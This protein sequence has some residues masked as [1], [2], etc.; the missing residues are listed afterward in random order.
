MIP[1]KTL[2]NFV[3]EG[4][5]GERHSI[6]KPFQW[7]NNIVATNGHLIVIVPKSLLSGMNGTYIN[8]KAPSVDDVVKSYDF[9]TDNKNISYKKL[10]A[11]FKT[12]KWVT[13]EYDTEECELCRSELELEVRKKIILTPFKWGDYK[14]NAE[15]LLKITD[16]LRLYPEDWFYYV[17]ENEKSKA[18]RFVFVNKNEIKIIIMGMRFDDE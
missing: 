15:C 1:I 14:I 10:V 3:R 6:N 9:K 17:E 2:E 7:K 16:I 18:H 4:E 12:I 11:L 8:E 5:D 13:T